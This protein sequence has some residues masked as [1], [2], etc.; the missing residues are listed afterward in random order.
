MQEIIKENIYN[1]L[2]EYGIE[3]NDIVLEKPKTREMGD[4][5]APCFT[6]AKILHKSPNDIANML[7]ENIKDFDIEVVNGY[8]N[9]FLNKEV[10]TKEVITRVLEEQDNYGSNNMGENKTVVIDYSSPNIAKPFGVGHLRST[11]IGEA[12]KRISLKCG[13]KVVGINHLG[14]WGTQFGKLI[15]AYLTW[16]SEEDLKENPIE[17]LR[18]LY[19]KFHS[20][21]EKDPSLDDE[22]RKWFKKLEDGDET[23]LKLW[24]Q[25][26]DFSIVEFDKTYKLLGIN[27]FDSNAGEAFYNDKMD[28]VVN[29]LNDKNLLVEDDGAMIVKLNDDMP[30]ALIKRTDGATLY[31]TRDLAAAIYRKETY[32]FDEALYVVGNEQTLHFKQLK[33]VLEKMGYPWANEIHHINFG[34]ILEDGK[35]MSTRSGKSVGLHS[36]LEEAISRAKKHIE[37]KNPNLENKEEV[38]EYVGVG[39]VIFNDLKNY[40]TNDIEFNLEDILEFSGNTGPYLQYT[41]AR[42]CSLLEKKTNTK[43]QKMS[44]NEDIWNIVFA[45]YQFS[46]IIT[47]SKQDYDP[48][49]IAKYLLDLANA[50]N[51]F[52]ANT[53]IIDDNLEETEFRLDICNI[54]AITLS[55]GLNLLGIHA[56]PQM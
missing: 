23:A 38:S 49:I 40:R 46:D 25:F 50:F 2:K 32:N 19:V 9:I 29:E 52:Y 42:I 56:I 16:G 18:K 24:Q 31:I 36:L 33:L 11:V 37:E 22:G 34:M 12:L 54:T 39:A 14:D 51:K 35:K 3:K 55:V 48:S 45:I 1:I 4:Y 27:N 53:R 10:I 7:K 6:Y 21:A 30:P 13:Y 26:R 44:I 15:Y 17:E 20:C 41:Y 5:A 43:Y 8:A 28:R 47:K